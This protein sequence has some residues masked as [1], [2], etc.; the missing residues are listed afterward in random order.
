[1]ARQRL[2]GH[3]ATFD[4]TGLKFSNGAAIRNVEIFD[5]TFGN[6]QNSLTIKTLGFDFKAT[7]GSGVDHLTFDTSQATIQAYAEFALGAGNDIVTLRASKQQL[8]VEGI[9]L[10]E[11]DDTITVGGATYVSARGV[12]GGAGA[13]SFAYV[14][15]AR[16]G[17]FDFVGGN[18]AAIDS[19]TISLSKLGFSKDDYI[20]T[21]RTSITGSERGLAGILNSDGFIGGGFTE[22]EAVDLTLTGGIDEM[23]VDRAAIAS[24]RAITLDG[25]GGLDRI[26]LDFSGRTGVSL[27][28]DAGGRYVSDALS[29]TKFEQFKLTLGGG[30]NT[31]TLGDG[32]DEIVSIDG[33][34]TIDM[35]GNTTIDRVPGVDRYSGS[36]TTTEDLTLT[37][38]AALTTISNGTIIRNAEMVN[39]ALGAGNDTIQVMAGARGTIDG[40]AGDDTFTSDGLTASMIGGLGNDALSATIAYGTIIDADSNGL[41]VGNSSGFEAM[42]LIQTSSAFSN[43]IVT[44]AAVASGLA[45]T[46]DAGAGMDRLD[47]DFSDAANAVF[48]VDE[49]N[50]ITSSFGTFTGFETFRVV[51]SAGTNDVALAYRDSTVETNRG[52]DTVTFASGGGRYDGFLTDAGGSYLLTEQNLTSSTGSVVRGANWYTLIGGVGVDTFTLR[53]ITTS[54][55]LSI[56][57]GGG[58]DTFVNESRSG[59]IVEGGTGSDTFIVR[60]GSARIWGFRIPDSWEYEAGPDLGTDMLVVTS[61]AVTTR[62]TGT[63]NGAVG[64]LSGELY[65]PGASAVEFTQIEAIDV[66]LGSGDDEIK[67]TRGALASAL[68]LKLNGGGGIDTIALDY[69]LTSN[70]VF[71]VGLDGAITAGQVVLSG[72]EAVDVTTGAGVNTVTGGAFAD[73]LTGSATIDGIGADTFDGRDGDDTLSGGLGNDV[74]RGGLGD[75]LLMGGAGNDTLDGGA[76]I[77]TASFADATSGVTIAL[78]GGAQVS[79]G[80]GTD[81]LTGIENLM[82]SAFGDTLTG[83][84]EANRISGGAG[85]DV[86]EGGLGADVLAGGSGADRFVYRSIQ[87][88]APGETIADFFFGA[89]TD[90]I[91]L[92]LIDPD[93]ALAGDQSFT[94]IGIADFTAGSSNYQLRVEDVGDRATLFKVEGDVDHD[95][96]AD[97]TLMVRISQDSGSI[98]YLAEGYFVL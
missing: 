93:A 63:I 8:S 88:F 28:A 42:S 34:D 54:L 45:L 82:G 80:S 16:G 10:G 73:R 95:G 86:L 77:D 19:I 14:A 81:T 21:T 72:F 40:G 24:G 70:L 18:D 5:L 37:L 57:G 9:D 94:F 62:T 13:D 83:D 75:D 39:Y 76:G 50:I 90:K 91:D 56:Y 4:K 20:V 35:G 55:N 48:K 85:T 87:D 23:T 58:D 22:M 78:I 26:S 92:S 44:R 12:T 52:V 29:L 11:G 3:D 33:I 89:T 79:G 27:S 59:G 61:D 74:L 25:G 1:M 15:N 71:A 36:A 66:T 2:G 97:F 6:G 41:R 67:L 30:T 51:L 96:I 31:V 84:A 38:A 53:D 65:A 17:S 68:S 49:S 7:F 69:S 32:N 64:G 43:T 98:S 47:I 60:S 46:M